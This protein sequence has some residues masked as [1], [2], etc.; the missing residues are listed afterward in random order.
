MPARERW[1]VLVGTLRCG[2]GRRSGGMACSLGRSHR[3]SSGLR[4]A[5]AGCLSSRPQPARA[6][7]KRARPGVVGGRGFLLL[8][9]LGCEVVERGVSSLA[10]VEALDVLEDGGAEIC[11]VGHEWRCTSSFLMVAKKLSATALSNASPF[12]PIETEMPASRACWPKPRA[13][14]CEPLIGM[15]YEPG[16][17]PAASDGHLQR[18]GDELA[19]HVLGHRPADDHPGE[20]SWTAAR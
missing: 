9:F 6:S 16:L 18:V 12:D 10:V 19:A 2:R 13:T 3:S 15:M 11:L 14:Y 20:P 17:R 1:A 8:V 5:T 4:W 7:G